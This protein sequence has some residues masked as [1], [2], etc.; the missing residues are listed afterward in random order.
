MNQERKAKVLASLN[1]F[2]PL[3][4]LFLLIKRRDRLVHFHAKQALGAWMFLGSAYVISLLPG[5]LFAV[6]KWPVTI[7]LFALFALHLGV[8]LRQAV[9]GHDKTLS[10][11][12]EWIDA[13]SLK[14]P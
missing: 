1:Y 3:F 11:V 13:L 6:A 5:S 10:P 7:T 8:G 9:G 14:R 12:G 2:P 4:L